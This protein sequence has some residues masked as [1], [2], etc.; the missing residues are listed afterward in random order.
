MEAE[1]SDAIVILQGR[2]GLW[3]LIVFPAAE[4]RAVEHACMERKGTK[5]SRGLDAVKQLIYAY[6]V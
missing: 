6:L 2:N 3:A 4:V 1:I 5:W